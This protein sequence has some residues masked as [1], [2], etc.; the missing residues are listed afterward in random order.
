[1]PHCTTKTP[2]KI[3]RLK[4]DSARPTRDGLNA[5]PIA[6]CAKPKTLDVTQN[7][8][9]PIQPV[10]LA[11][12]MLKARVSKLKGTPQ[13]I[14]RSALQPRLIKR[15]ASMPQPQKATNMQALR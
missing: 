2:A 8:A 5:M 11:P 3:I 14:K 6:G 1:M 4:A 13:A 12:A 9:Q 10:P 7:T 15:G